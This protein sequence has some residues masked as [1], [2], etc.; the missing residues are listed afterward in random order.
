MKEKKCP[1]FDRCAAYIIREKLGEKW[2]QKFCFADFENC[3]HYQDRNRIRAF[4]TRAEKKI[5][6]LLKP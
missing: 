1:F 2:S 6:I 3:V 5:E 4:I